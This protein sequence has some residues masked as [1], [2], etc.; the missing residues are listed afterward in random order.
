LAKYTYGLLSLEQYHKIEKKTD[1][2]VKSFQHLVD[3]KQCFPLDFKKFNLSGNYPYKEG[4]MV[5]IPSKI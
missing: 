5:I 2:Q 1:H 4:K 3:V